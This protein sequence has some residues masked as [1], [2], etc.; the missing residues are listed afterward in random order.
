MAGSVSSSSPAGLC[1]ALSRPCVSLFFSFLCFILSSSTLRLTFTFPEFSFSYLNHSPSASSSVPLRQC[2]LA[3]SPPSSRRKLG[4]VWLFA[5]QIP[6]LGSCCSHERRDIMRIQPKTLESLIQ[7]QLFK[8]IRFQQ[9]MRTPHEASKNR[10]SWICALLLVF[11]QSI[12][13]MLTC[14]AVLSQWLQPVLLPEGRDD[15]EMPH[16]W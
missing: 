15:A 3:P 2:L 7:Q 13:L 11:L 14:L 6:S 5:D 1:L 12:K 9:P 10:R 16:E 8:H 4:S